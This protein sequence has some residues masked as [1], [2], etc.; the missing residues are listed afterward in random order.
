MGILTLILN[1]LG[2]GVV[3]SLADA[4]KAKEAARTDQERIAADERI[5]R[6]NAIRDVQRA[7][8]GSKLNAFVRL[9]FAFPVAV[10][11][12][13]LYLYDKVLALGSTDPLS[14]DLQWT[15]RVI[16]GFYFLY[17]FGRVV[18]RR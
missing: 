8:A 12:G 1:F 5:N 4:Y 15:A 14:D 11:Y 16:I 13:K 10:Y 18:K 17:E 9:C 6:L 7:E 2:G 3:Q